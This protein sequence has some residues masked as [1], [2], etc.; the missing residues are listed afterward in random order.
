MFVCNKVIEEADLD[1]DGK[2][3]FADFEDMIAKSPDFIRCCVGRAGEGGLVWGAARAW[4]PG[5][6]GWGE[7]RSLLRTAEVPAGPGRPGSRKEVASRSSFL[8]V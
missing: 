2:L 8:S 7:A 3:G 6:R 5:A 4:P 1:G